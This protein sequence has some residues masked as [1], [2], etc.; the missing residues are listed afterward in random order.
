MCPLLMAGVCD[1]G[2]F[3]ERSTKEVANVDFEGGGSV[4][5]AKNIVRNQCV[6]RRDF[7][8]LAACFQGY[9]EVIPC[10]LV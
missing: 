4:N 6:L 8:M 2:Y 1:W 10:S 7:V 9:Q 5:L 3:G